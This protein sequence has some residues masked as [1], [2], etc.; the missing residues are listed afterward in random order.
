[1]PKRCVLGAGPQT[2]ARRRHQNDPPRRCQDAYGLV[3]QALRVVGLFQCM[4][5]H[6]PVERSGGERQR[7]V[8]DQH[9]AILADRSPL[10]DPL[11]ARHGS[12]QTARAD[13]G[14]QPRRGIAYAQNVAVDRLPPGVVET[15][16]QQATDERPGGLAIEGSKLFDAVAHAC[17]IGRAAPPC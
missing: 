10:L 5:Q 2:A 17:S 14:V 7:P 13:K 8:I 3:Q 6:D 11:T 9:G 15:P 12:D 1:M 4:D 16:R